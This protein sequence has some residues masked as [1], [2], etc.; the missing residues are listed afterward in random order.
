ME[1]K[2]KNKKVIVVSSI[3][4]VITIVVLLVITL[5]DSYAYYGGSNEL[6]IIEA[7][8]GKLKPTIDKVYIENENKQ[9]TNNPNPNVTITWSDDNITEY[10]VTLDSNCTEFNQLSDTDT[11]KKSVTATNQITLSGEGPHTVNVYIKNKYGYTSEVK[12]DQITLDTTPP[13]IKSLSTTEIKETSVTIKVTANSGDISGIKQYCYST[14]GSDYKCENMVNGEKTFTISGLE[15]GK[16]YTLYIYLTDNAGNNSVPTQQ[17][18]TTIS[19][20]AKDVVVATSK[21][22]ETEEKMKSRNAQIS[23]TQDDLRRFVGPYTTV[24]DNFICF[25]TTDKDECTS[26]R[27]TYMYRIMGIDTSG[28]LKLIKATKIVTDNRKTFQWNFIYNSIVKWNASDLYKGLNGESPQPSNSSACNQCFVGNS[29]YSYMQEVQWTDLIDPTTYYIG[30]S[31]VTNNP[32]VFQNERGESFDNAKISLMYLSDYLYANNGAADKSNWLLMANGLNGVTNTPNGT[33]APSAE[34]EWTMTRHDY[35]T[36]H[37]TA[38]YV[39]KNGTSSW[40]GFRD[41]WAVRPVF[42][43]KS[44]IQ[45]SD[46][47]G[48]IETPYMI[49]P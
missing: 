23:G 6:P 42:Y 31:K 41:T 26:N 47:N 13:A 19:K 21:S 20:S 37:Y 39:V 38:W 27:D 36:D 2:L 8:I 32:T 10:C 1:E 45:I 35:D 16:S 18:F 9:Y 15:G 3:I 12:S 28:R 17:K 49:A 43:L 14:T 40:D 48:Q 11:S 29:K 7:T 25:G 24:N 46:G 33:D 22:L 5:K 30:N 44:T 4:L 34:N